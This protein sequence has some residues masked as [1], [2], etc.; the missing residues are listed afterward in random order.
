[1]MGKD[2]DPWNTAAE[3]LKQLIIR[4]QIVGLRSIINDR[5]LREVNID[6]DV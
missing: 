2:I 1:M 6:I 4:A 5:G 3:D